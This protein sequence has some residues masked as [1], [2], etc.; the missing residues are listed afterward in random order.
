MHRRHFDSHTF[1]SIRTCR[2]SR[3][4]SPPIQLR[5]LIRLLT[6]C[7]RRPST[8]IMLIIL[9]I[10]II[11]QPHIFTALRSVFFSVIRLTTAITVIMGIGVIAGTP[12]LIRHMHCYAS[13]DLQAETVAYP[14][15]VDTAKQESCGGLA[16]L[17]HLA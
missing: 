10:P 2:H 16:L 6:T 9:T 1:Q 11:I 13:L 7:M 5:P 12:K 15:P 8:P 3:G 17:L 14:Q 4:R